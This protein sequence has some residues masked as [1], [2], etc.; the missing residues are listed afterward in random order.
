MENA[1]LNLIKFIESE[2][3]T[4]EKDFQSSVTASNTPNKRLDVLS[5]EMDPNFK[6]QFRA[7]KRCK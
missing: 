6:K 7:H 3:S 5:S 1:D 2:I 4:L